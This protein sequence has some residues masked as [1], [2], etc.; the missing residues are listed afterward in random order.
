[1]RKLKVT[2]RFVNAI[3]LDKWTT[4][5]FYIIYVIKRFKYVAVI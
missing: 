4:K 3:K 1:M 5:H 2:F